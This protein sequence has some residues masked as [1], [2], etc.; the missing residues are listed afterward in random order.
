VTKPDLVS[1]I[2]PVYNGEKYLAEALDSIVRQSYRPIEVIVVDDGS[3]DG[4]HEV[5]S[6][7]G[8]QLRYLRQANAGPAAAR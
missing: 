2:V 6:S 1:C 3:T 8:N 4:T 7:C 5:V